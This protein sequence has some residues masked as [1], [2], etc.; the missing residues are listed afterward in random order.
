L[1]I[2]FFDETNRYFGDYH[3]V[4]L[5]AVLTFDPGHPGS[6]DLT[7]TTFWDEFRATVGKTL[8]VER[9]L[10]RMGVPGADVEQT[11]ADLIDDFLKAAH[12]YMAHPGYPRRLAQPELDRLNKTGRFY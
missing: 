4:S 10:E 8:L 11:V 12:D 2:D 1:Q 3:R 5:R 7:D 6:A 9:K